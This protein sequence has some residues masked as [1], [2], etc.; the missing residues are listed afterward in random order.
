M[1]INNKFHCSFQEIIFWEI[2]KQYISLQTCLP[3]WYSQCHFWKKKLNQN[4]K[5]Q[6]LAKQD[7][8]GVKSC[9]EK[10]KNLIYTSTGIIH[11]IM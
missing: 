7:D 3:S 2:L 4:L 9:N 8:A 5:P 1:D 6:E 10:F 11:Q